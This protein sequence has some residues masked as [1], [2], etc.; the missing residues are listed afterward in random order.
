VRTKHIG[1]KE[2]FGFNRHR[3]PRE[4]C[5]GRFSFPVREQ[6]IMQPFASRGNAPSGRMAPVALSRSVV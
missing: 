3:D 6:L 4:G 5:L 2:R 1:P